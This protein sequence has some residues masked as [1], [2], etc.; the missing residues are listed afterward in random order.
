MERARHWQ[1][2]LLLG[3][4]TW[5]NSDAPASTTNLWKTQLD[6]AILGSPTVA[7]NGTI[8][9]GTARLQTDSQANNLRSGKF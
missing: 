9:V 7:D 3:L 1:A 4:I 2:A 5:G 8:Y 6:A